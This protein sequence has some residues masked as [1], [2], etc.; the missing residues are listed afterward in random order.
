LTGQGLNGVAYVV[1]AYSSSTPY[2][3]G[4]TYLDMLLLP[5]P[6]WIYSSKPDWYG[7]DDITRAMGWP[8]TTQSAVT[9]PGEAFANFGWFGLPVALVFGVIFWA[10][11]A[12][13]AR[14]AT[15]NL[16][17]FPSV[18]FYVLFVTNWMSMTGLMNQLLPLL[19]VVAVTRA[20]LKMPNGKSVPAIPLGFR[21]ALKA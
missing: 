12:L 21:A 20:A 16:V 19:C 7:I 3:W 14:A 10:L 17:I 4:K 2:F 13:S 1:S 6:R 9:I 8:D 11:Y 15:R 18:T 5:V